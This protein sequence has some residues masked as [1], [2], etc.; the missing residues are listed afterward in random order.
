MTHSLRYAVPT[1]LLL[2]GFAG[3]LVFGFGGGQNTAP[4]P[5]ASPDQ[6]A[7]HKT[8]E[9]FVT[10]FNAG[11]AKGAAAAFAPAG[12]FIDDDANRLE[13][14]AAIEALLTKFFAANKGAK[15]QITPDGAR[16]VAPGVVIEDGESCV[17]V[18]DKATQSTRRYAMVY[19]MIDGAW[20]IASIREYPDAGDNVPPAEKL[21]VL[22]WMI[23]DWVE[24]GP[25]SNLLISCKWSA[26]KSHLVRDFSVRHKGKDVL[27]GTQLISVDPATG[28]I[29]G[30]A[31]DSEGGHG[32][33]TW[34]QNGD[35]WLVYGRGV[36]SDGD[37]AAATYILKPIGKD[38]VEWKTMNKVVGDS[39]EP[40]VTTILVRKLAK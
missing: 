38:R 5:K 3:G 34:T 11:D 13:G 32:E 2:A 18:P 37:V 40:D 21:K 17:T 27:R 26:D 6:D 36:T 4:A 9:T 10:G 39:V 14:S 7:V 30:W 22:E 25:D 20:R 28:S 16:T 33:T 35:S 23:G 15:I 24:E 29:T 12:E 8:L 31:L 1:L 19:V